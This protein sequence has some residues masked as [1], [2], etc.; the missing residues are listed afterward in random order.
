[1]LMNLFV[2]KVFANHD[3]YD[4]L[5]IRRK[6]IHMKVGRKT[7]KTSSLKQALRKCCH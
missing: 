4:S 5:S 6:K 7:N 2:F 1:M 3:G